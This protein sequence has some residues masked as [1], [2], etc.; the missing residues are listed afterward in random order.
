M[1]QFD[2]LLRERAQQ[3]PFPLPEDYAG[4][5][6]RTCANLEEDQPRKEKRR[7][8]RRSAWIAAAVALFVA[9][10]NVSPA[11]AAALAEVPVIGAIV[12]LVTFRTYNYDDGH[13]FADVTV[14]QLD[15]SAAARELS[16]RINED[17][18]QLIARF[19]E[20]CG[21]V[22]E[23]Y[24]GLN[25]TSSVVTDTDRWF[26]IR[27]DAVET[28][29]SG[30]EFSRFYHI[31]RTSGTV[32]TLADLFGVDTDYVLV[33]S[34]E[35]RRQMEEQMAAGGEQ[36]YFIDEFT[37]I[38]PDQDFYWNEDGDLVLFFDEY[39][40]AAGAMGTPEFTIPSQVYR[41]LLK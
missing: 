31:D 41:E 34:D 3:E 37:S 39:T 29:A 15:G 8:P 19:Q 7:R 27:V 23:G 33:L 32:A 5:V 2:Q 17:I 35:V 28:Q 10:P 40:V 36:I 26:T 12:E 9:V 14:P 21:V 25:V 4:R 1:D 20:E 24:Q 11:A 6:F 30:Y 18:D 22:G 38:D 13:S 16:A